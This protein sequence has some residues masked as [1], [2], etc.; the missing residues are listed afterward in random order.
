MHK[1]AQ[2]S[3]SN[4][5]EMC[6]IFKHNSLQITIEANKKVVDFLD[7]T[8]DLRT[9]IYKPYKKSNSNLTYIHKQS[10]HPPS[11]INNLPKSINKRLS[12]NSKNAQIFNEACP[13]YTEVL[14]KNGYN[15]NLQFDRT[16]TDKN[17]EKNK[18]R[19]RKITWFNPPFN[20]NVATNVANTFLTLIDYTFQ[21][22]K[23]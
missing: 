5:K 7:I 3:R 22:T 20:I 21:R 4:K 17:N 16:C 9:A 12:T 1:T 10:N 6:K 14:K 15:R 19:K 13:A 8:L 23:G 2:A 18:I 11:I